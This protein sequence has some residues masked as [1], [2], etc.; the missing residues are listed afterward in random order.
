MATEIVRLCDAHMARDDAR[1]PASQY[2][3]VMR[4]VGDPFA[5]VSVDLCDD[6]AKPLSDL[7][8]D[9]VELGRPFDEATLTQVQAGA[10]KP[11]ARR[12]A[13]RVAAPIAQAHTAGTGV[14]CPVCDKTY[15][16]KSSLQSHTRGEHGKTL[17][18]LLGESLDYVCEVDGC[19]R[20]FTT[21]QGL[22]VHQ[23]R[24][25]GLARVQPARSGT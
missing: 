2:D 24:I 15:A 16:N 9:L 13:A 21:I 8:S 4:R 23:N 11:A 18:E 3:V 5:F 19:G 1:V 12:A 22:A 7:L 20:G 25:H 10:D 6:C 14:Q 17:G